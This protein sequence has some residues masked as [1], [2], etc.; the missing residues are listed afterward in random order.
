METPFDT[1]RNIIWMLVIT[2]ALSIWPMI[3]SCQWQIRDR[4]L[5]N[6]PDT[7]PETNIGPDGK[8][9]SDGIEI[10]SDSDCLAL[11]R[12]ESSLGV[13]G[14]ETTWWV[15]SEAEG[16]D[17]PCYI[18]WQLQN[19]NQRLDQHINSYWPLWFSWLPLVFLII[20]IVKVRKARRLLLNRDAQPNGQPQSHLY[21]ARPDD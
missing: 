3:V 13:C 18:S 21:R 7:Y 20:V 2:F 12:P 6:W 10:V 17:G 4:E 15:Q 11:S 14:R 16:C 9:Y 19:E 8:I 1:L 5:S